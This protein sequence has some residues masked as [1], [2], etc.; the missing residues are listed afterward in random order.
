MCALP[1]PA[2]ENLLHDPLV[3]PG[4]SYQLPG[5][6]STQSNLGSLMVKTA[7]PVSLGASSERQGRFSPAEAGPSM[8]GNTLPLRYRHNHEMYVI[9]A[10]ITCT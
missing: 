7:A 9:V 5:D 6:T 1:G 8:S 3:S 4:T 10:S 2:N